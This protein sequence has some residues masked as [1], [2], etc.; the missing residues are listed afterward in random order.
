MPCRARPGRKRESG[1]QSGR[2]SRGPQSPDTLGAGRGG[3]EQGDD[4]AD[5]GSVDASQAWV[6]K[7][8]RAEAPDAVDQEGIP[9][10]DGVFL[11][12]LDALIKGFTPE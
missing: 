7:L 11:A 2:S 4:G 5:A 1:Q 8:F 9:P 3:S 6:H 12:G 10:E